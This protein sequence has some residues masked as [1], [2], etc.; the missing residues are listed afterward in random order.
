MWH[1]VAAL[2][3]RLPLCYFLTRATHRGIEIYAAVCVRLFSRYCY[4]SSFA[5]S[6]VNKGLEIKNKIIH[7][8]N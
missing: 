3:T 4:Y 1:V 7:I 8:L 5:L 2:H 6:K